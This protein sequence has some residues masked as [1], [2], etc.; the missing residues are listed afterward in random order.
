MANFEPHLENAGTPEIP[1]FRVF[2][3]YG[4]GGFTKNGP[5][6]IPHCASHEELA[7]QMHTLLLS[8]EA[9]YQTAR[10]MLTEN[11]RN[12]AAVCTPCAVP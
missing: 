10:A 2:I 3:T 5:K 6:V 12:S 9:A 7:E 4:N 11:A 1:R 8:L